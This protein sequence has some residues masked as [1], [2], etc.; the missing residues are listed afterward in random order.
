MDEYVAAGRLALRLSKGNVRLVRVGDADRQ[1][2]QAVRIAAVNVVRTFRRAAI[3]LELFVSIRREA[4]ADR[5]R[6]E[7]SVRAIEHQ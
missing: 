4:K 7:H 2:K 1:M 5:V 3:A 6:F